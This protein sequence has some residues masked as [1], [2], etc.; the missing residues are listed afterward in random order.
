MH[1]M[2]KFEVVQDFQIWA[3]NF[4]IEQLAKVSDEEFNA[5]FGGFEAG[6]LKHLTGFLVD[7]LYLWI[8]R[9]KGTSL[10]EFPHFD[11]LPRAELL[12]LWQEY[13]D[14][15]KF[16]FEDKII[17]N[18]SYR[19]TKGSKFWNTKYDILVHLSAVT[20]YYRGMIVLQLRQ[21]G[22]TVEDHDY[23]HLRR[24]DQIS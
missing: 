20:S 17:E 10:E 6:S 9:L 24:K 22:K 14:E 18:V 15:L 5:I 7:T 2:A 13:N 21:L 12:K 8:Q 11:K 4:L 1:D 16:Y 19:N 3:D 23:I